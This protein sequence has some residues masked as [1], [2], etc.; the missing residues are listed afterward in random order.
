M[1]KLLKRPFLPSWLIY[2]VAIYCYISYNLMEKPFFL[3]PKQVTVMVLIMVSLAIYYAL[4]KFVGWKKG[5][6][7]VIYWMSISFFL[8]LLYLLL[9]R[10]THN[11]ATTRI[12]DNVPYHISLNWLIMLF[13][14]YSLGTLIQY[15]STKTTNLLKRLFIYLLIDS[16]IFTVYTTLLDG[17]G[18]HAGYWTWDSMDASILVWGLIPAYV[19]IEYFIGFMLIML[20]VRWFEIYKKEPP[21]I[22]PYYLWGNF[23]VYIGW[24]LYVATS[25]WAFRKGIDIVG[26]AG[27]IFTTILTIIIIIKQRQ[28]RK[29]EYN[30]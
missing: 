15:Q 29:N 5:T 1:N 12:F 27:I 9:G 8:E 19:F 2:I 11:E 26:Y 21:S 6:W 18:Q 4:S 25:Y 22:V 14:V 10:F 7:Y 13:A 28:I 20:P 23:P 30:R 16:I 24:G 3:H 17:V